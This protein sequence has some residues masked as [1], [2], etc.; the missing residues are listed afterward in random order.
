MND[1]ADA[2]SRA[3]V[4]RDQESE[5]KREEAAMDRESVTML[6]QE[7]EKDDLKGHQEGDEEFEV[8]AI[9]ARMKKEGRQEK[10]Y[11]QI[12]NG[13][14]MHSNKPNATEEEDFSCESRNASSSPGF[15][16][17]GDE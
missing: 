13:V 9:K 4:P 1:N 17:C 7:V 6:T 8:K 10:K 5:N 2:P 11:F 3:P 16:M 15:R 12:K 14:L